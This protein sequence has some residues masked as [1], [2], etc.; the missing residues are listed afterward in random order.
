MIR[1]SHYKVRQFQNRI[2]LEWESL[3]LYEMAFILKEPWIKKKCSI[4]KSE[5]DL[6][7]FQMKQIQ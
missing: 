6:L 5:W 1:N 7:Y 4:N 3:Y 2:S